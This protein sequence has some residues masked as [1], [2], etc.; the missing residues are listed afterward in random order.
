MGSKVNVVALKNWH[1]SI[2]VKYVF[3]V[4]EFPEERHSLTVEQ[5]LEND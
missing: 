1:G 3:T 4:K 2:D 5:E